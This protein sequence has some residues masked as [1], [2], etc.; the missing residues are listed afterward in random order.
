M[1]ESR[2]IYQRIEAWF[3]DRSSATDAGYSTVNHA[4]LSSLARRLWA[5]IAFHDFWAQVGLA[6]LLQGLEERGLPWEGDVE[7]WPIGD[8]DD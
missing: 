4:D 1:S 3:D 7:D 2:T 5:P 8:A 6:A